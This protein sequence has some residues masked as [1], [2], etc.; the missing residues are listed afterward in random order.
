[1]FFK[2]ESAQSINYFYKKYVLIINKIK[3]KMF[4]QI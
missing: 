2:L 3:V 1:M 4:T